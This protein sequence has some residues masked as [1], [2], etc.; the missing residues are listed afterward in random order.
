MPK[1][2]ASM[3]INL[4]V[5]STW[6]GEKQQ[7]S[8]PELISRQAFNCHESKVAPKNWS[9]DLLEKWH[10]SNTTANHWCLKQIAE[11][12][13]FYFNRQKIINILIHIKNCLINRGI[14]VATTRGQL[15]C[16]FFQLFQSL[17][18]TQI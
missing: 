10:S 14:Y 4:L 17:F 7:Y 3:S 12:L 1:A 13:F 8:L 16:G 15:N 11:A 2:T 6:S 18:E 5:S 9:R